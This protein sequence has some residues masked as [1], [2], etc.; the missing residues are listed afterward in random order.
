MPDKNPLLL[1]DLSSVFYPIWHMSG[2]DPDVNRPSID[3]VAKVRAL[4]YGVDYC[5]V[6]CDSGRSFRKDLDASYKA[7]RPERDERLQHQLTLTRE[8]LEKD[9]F[10]VWAVS[11]F[12]ADDLIASACAKAMELDVPVLIASSDKDLLQLVCPTVEA[13]S[14]TNGNV[15]DSAAVE[16]KFGVTPTQMRDYLSLVGDSSDNIKGAP[17]IGAVGAKNILSIHGSLQALYAKLDAGQDAK[18]L[19]LTPSIFKTLVESRALI[20]GAQALVTLRTDVPLPF[21]TVLQPR[22]PQ[23]TVNQETGEL[24]EEA[25]GVLQT[26]KDRPGEQFTAALKHHEAREQAV[27]RQSLVPMPKAPAVEWGRELEPR[28]M[29]DAVKLAKFM[30]E[31]RLFSAY[32]TTQAVLSTILAGR[33]LGMGAM[34]SLRGMHIIDGKPT[35]SAGLMA[36]LVMQSGK[37]QYFSCTSTTNEAAT[38]KTHRKGD[39]EPCEVSFTM[40]D[41]QRAGLVKKGSGWEKYPAD[42]LT[43]RATVRLARLKYPDICFGLY[44]PSELGREDLDVQV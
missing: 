22:T 23:T 5:V 3:A 28:S 24:Q 40:E 1:V 43:A 4:A 19:N 7:N 20:E 11:G 38:F 27:V 32:G 34:A 39:P 6:C 26:E 13:K 30:F 9:G 12:E 21:E 8:T 18:L 44:T 35:L 31:S 37:A 41:A 2:S 33:E 36:A 25:K 17:G 29:D 10:P 16:A 42:M 15:F 14:L